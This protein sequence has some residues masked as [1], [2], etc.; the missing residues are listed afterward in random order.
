M[1][2]SV[3][4]P[5]VDS[6]IVYYDDATGERVALT[7]DELGGVGPGDRVLIDAAASEEPRIWLAPLFAGAALVLCANPDRSRLDKRIA[8]ERVTRVL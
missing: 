1:T 8:A 7:A 5:A 3:A 4:Q 2:Q 6:L